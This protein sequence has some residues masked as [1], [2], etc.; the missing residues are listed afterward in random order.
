MTALFNHEC[1]LIADSNNVHEFR[2]LVV[3]PNTSARLLKV[4]FEVAPCEREF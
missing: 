3:R 1:D 2:T 4:S